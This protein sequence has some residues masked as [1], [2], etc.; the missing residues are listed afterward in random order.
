MIRF[1]LAEELDKLESLWNALY[2]HQRSHGMRIALPQAAF[3]AWA[4][5][6]RPSLNRFAIV[7]VAETVGRFV[8]FVAG[9]VRMLPPHF[10]SNPVGF[11]GEVF[12]ADKHRSGGVGAK[13]LSSA[14]EWYRA[15]GVERIELQVVS[16]NPDALR[17]YERLG[18]SP[19][20][21]QLTFDTRGSL[22]Q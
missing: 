21:V 4:T 3:S 2:E 15:N 1:A 22:D 19:E 6:I 5:A 8:G 17:F 9:R 12:V 13:L 20:L 16:G 18:W 11:I 7:V 10:G 14:I